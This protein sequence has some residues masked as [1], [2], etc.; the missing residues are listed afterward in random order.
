MHAARSDTNETKDGMQHGRAQMHL[1][2]PLIPCNSNQTRG[3]RRESEGQYRRLRERAEQP[4]AGD[5]PVR[6]LRHV[7][8]VPAHRPGRVRARRRRGEAAERGGAE[9]VPAA[10][11]HQR[12]A[13]VEPCAAVPIARH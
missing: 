2:G 6:R 5:A 3:S 9:V 10:A 13:A 4:R 7:D 8:A 1:H 12:R 11:R